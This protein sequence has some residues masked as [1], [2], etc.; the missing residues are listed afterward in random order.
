MAMTMTTAAPPAPIAVEG[1]DTPAR[2]LRRRCAQWAARPA[3]R[4]KRKGIWRTTTWRGYGEAVEA[5]AAAMMAAGIGRG[6]VVAILA[7]NRPEWVEA[8][9]AALSLGAIVG[10]IYPTAQA[11][12]VGAILAHSGARLL[13]VEN[14]EQLDKALSARGRAPRLDRIVVMDLKGLRSL[15]DERTTALADFLAGGRAK[16][17]ELRGAIAREADAGGPDDIALLLYSG[18]RAAQ[19]KAAAITNR[20]LMFQIRAIGRVFDL[21]AQAKSVSL[22]SLCHPIEHALT[23]QGQLGL[24]QIVHFPE[25]AGTGL[26]DL[27]EVGP[28][29]VFAPPRLWETLQAGIERQAREAAPLGRAAYRLAIGASIRSVV[30]RLIRRLVLGR[31]RARLGMSHIRY[32]LTGGAPVPDTVLRWS[33]ALGIP[34]LEVYGTAE[35]AGLCTS[36][37]PGAAKPGFAGRRLDDGVELRTDASGEIWV[38]GPGV[39]LGYWP[40]AAEP[41]RRPDPD[42]W[43]ATGD[44][45]AIDGDGFLG[46]RGR[47]EDTLTLASG[48]AVAPHPIEAQLRGSAHIA[49]C[50]VAG[51]G[52]PH[53]TCLV[54]LD[55]DAVA[56]FARA[57]QIPVSEVAALARHPAVRE[58]IAAEIATAAAMLPA[59]ERPRDFRIL[60]HVPAA[61][62]EEMTAL[63]TLDRRVVLQKYGALV[64]EM[65]AGRVRIA[66]D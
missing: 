38:R 27:A 12:Q 54:V 23:A 47:I 58:L 44:R 52:R 25:N 3:L 24:G 57:Q 49:D 6:D 35:T 34:L 2:L 64:G 61:D 8:E 13:F 51:D 63:L 53:L 43:L 60:D 30:G 7:E 62:D 21:P 59:A 4:H 26:N 11:D 33:A 20:N 48:E 36:A 55:P 28:E 46:W 5:L 65:Y 50:I 66:A 1:E 15:E 29:L 17:A 18:R 56:A 45:G 39:F 41:H 37:V 19:P 14:E 32:A 10:G 42:G 40:T 22:L 31:V 16:A 9:F